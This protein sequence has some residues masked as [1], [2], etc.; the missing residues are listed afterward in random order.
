MKIETTFL[1]S[2]VALRIF[3]LFVCCALLPIAVLAILSYS[4]VTKQLNEQT[5]KRLQQASKDVGR[6]IAERLYFLEG[7]MKEGAFN[8]SKE[9]NPTSYTPAKGVSDFLKER[10]EGLT[11]VTGKGENILLF[12]HM[13]NIPKLTLEQK[14][15]IRSGGTNVS[16]EIFPDSRAHIFMSMAVDPRS[17]RRGI[18]LGKVAVAYLWGPTN[19]LPIP[20]AIELCI[21]DQSNNALFSSLP[22]S[23]SFPKGAA[24]KMTQTAKGQFEWANGGKEYLA[25]YRCVFL[26][27][28]LFM[29]KWTVVVSESKSDALAPAANFKKIFLLTLLMSLWVVS[30]LSVIQI[31][32]SL[33]PLEK[34]QE[35]T[36]RIATQDFNSPVT[37]KSG[38]EFEELAASFNTM[39][40]RLGKQF[41]TLTTMGEIDRAILSALDTGKII[42]VVLTGIPDVLL[43]DCVSV[44][45]LDYGDK[46][47]GRTYTGSGKPDMEKVVKT[48]HLSA[49][50]IHELESHPQSLFIELGEAVP[51]YLASTV[52]DG[53]K[54]SL[55]L[56]II[57]KKKLSGFITLGWHLKPTLRIQEDLDRAR[58]LADQMGVALSNASLIR[59]LNALN[60]GTLEALARAIDAKSPWT[61]GHSERVTKLALKIGQSLGLAQE[62]MDILHRAGLLHDI[63]KLGIPMDIL[64]KEEKLTKEEEQLM[65]EHVRLGIRILEPIAA[66]AEVVPVVLHHHEYFDGEGYPEGL[67]GKAISLGGRIFAVADSFDALT[68]NRPYRQALNREYAIEMIKQGCG[69]QYDPDIVRAFLEVMAQESREGEA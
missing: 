4:Q 27:S 7:E 43:C 62:E 30:L 64:D 63:G 68:S 52:R 3:V 56:P 65:H 59:E 38:D 6:A 39:A 23:V 33:I 51:S 57:L 49:A 48:I 46:I 16:S 19:E 40:S 41:S 29:P 24:L 37:I 31:R 8:L 36:R 12:G 18:L 21:L 10:F 42:D 26:Q 45:L 15:H 2:K 13:Q 5:Q 14:Q 50:E 58:Q 53:T 55:I 25:S 66:Y 34:L 28:A 35:G 60:W 54:T 67:A 1:R 47:I 17:P 69:S 44:T 32:R 11:L 22:G 20:P 61:A 9:S